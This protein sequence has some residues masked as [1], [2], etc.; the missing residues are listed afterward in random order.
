[1]TPCAGFFFGPRLHALFTRDFSEECLHAKTE[2]VHSS[3]FI[4]VLYSLYDQF[5]VSPIPRSQPSIFERVRVREGSKSGRRGGE[6]RMEG[7]GERSR[8]LMDILD[9]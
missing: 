7:R 3:V 1:M 9:G 5:H 6:G 8:K 2:K 4:R